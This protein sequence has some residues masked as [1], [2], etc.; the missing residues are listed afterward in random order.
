M[1][2]TLASGPFNYLGVHIFNGK[3]CIIHLQAIEDKLK[4]NLPL[5]NVNT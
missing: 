2:F 5:G 3:P 1:G 4:P